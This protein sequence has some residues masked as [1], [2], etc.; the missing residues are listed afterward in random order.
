M[1]TPGFSDDSP[2]TNQTPLRWNTQ[3]GELVASKFSQ[4]LVASDTLGHLGD[5]GARA[6]NPSPGVRREIAR[7]R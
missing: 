7:D 3:R 5:R 6:G 2:A 1:R 4:N